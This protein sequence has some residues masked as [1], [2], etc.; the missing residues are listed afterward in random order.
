MSRSK[1]LMAIAA[2]LVSTAPLHAQIPDSIQVGTRLRVTD[3]SGRIVTGNLVESDTIVVLHSTQRRRSYSMPMAEVQRVEVSA[4]RHRHVL[5]YTFLTMGISAVGLGAVAAAAWEPC[6]SES[7][8]SC[9]LA[10]DSRADEFLVF[11][12]VGGV[13]GVPLGLLVGITSVHEVWREAGTGSL[14]APQPS[15][16]FVPLPGG[17]LGLGA[18]IPV[19]KR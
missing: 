17:G 12:V 19:G 8:F 4:G 16:G 7:L 15:L 5:R 6:E 14:A 1:L 10:T 2:L 18:S 13:L 11:A 9:L 3:V